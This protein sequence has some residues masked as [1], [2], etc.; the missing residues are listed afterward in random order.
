[1]E[2]LDVILTEGQVLPRAEDCLHDLGIAGDFLLIAAGE[3][4]NFE[5]GQ[6]PLDL[7]IRELAAFDSSGGTDAFNRGHMAKRTQSSG[8]SVPKALHAPLNSSI[9][10]IK[11]R[12]SGVM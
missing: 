4:S 5:I 6:Q 10:A 7:P 8:A 12:T 11:L 2:L 3:R 1:V 9:P